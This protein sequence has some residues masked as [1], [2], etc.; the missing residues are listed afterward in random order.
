MQTMKYDILIFSGSA[1]SGKGTVLKLARELC[2]KLCLSISMTTRAPRPGEVHGREY[3]FVTK[4][5]FL[6][7]LSR[8]GLLEHTEYCG[9]YYGT[10][11][12]QFFE[13]IENGL[14]PVL[15]IETDGA[16]QVMKK[17]DRYLSVY[18]TPPNYATLE[19]R[20]RGRG[21]ETEESIQKRLATAKEEILCSRFY[22]NMIINPDGNASEAASA[23]VELLEHGSTEKTVLVRDREAFLAQFQK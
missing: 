16:E 12:K 23:I 7:T 10:P 21:T 18:L 5:E 17:L 2:P 11:K 6:E 1:G 13:M 15:E 22:E 3:Y 8:D 20:L 4:E 14:V 19:A 9:N